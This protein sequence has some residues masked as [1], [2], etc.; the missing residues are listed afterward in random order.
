MTNYQSPYGMGPATDALLDA[1]A[2]R[3]GLTP[4]ELNDEISEEVRHWLDCFSWAEEIGP[5][6]DALEDRIFPT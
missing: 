3:R 1:V 6:V 2:D 4:D 5:V